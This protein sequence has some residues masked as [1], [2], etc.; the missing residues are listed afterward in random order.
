MNQG[1]APTM[2][3]VNLDSLTKRK[4]RAEQRLQAQT[5]ALELLQA[6]LAL[7][8]K[9]A[10]LAAMKVRLRELKPTTQKQRDAADNARAAKEAKKNEAL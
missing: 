3:K 9:R 10:E 4:E 2:P 1:E 5:V 6:Q 8:E 7:Q